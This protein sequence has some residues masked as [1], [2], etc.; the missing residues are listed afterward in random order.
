MLQRIESALPAEMQK[1]ASGLEWI[2]ICPVCRRNVEAEGTARQVVLA[3][4][5]NKS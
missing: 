2:R 4:R 3:R 5:K 1:D